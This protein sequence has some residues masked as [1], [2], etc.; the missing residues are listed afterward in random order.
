MNTYAA[1][2]KSCRLS[3]QEM[4]LGYEDKEFREVRRK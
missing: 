2:D 1:V 4:F 3:P